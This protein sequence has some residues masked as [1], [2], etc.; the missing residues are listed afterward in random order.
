VSG[1]RSE[2]DLLAK[3]SDILFRREQL[4]LRCKISLQKQIKVSEELNREEE[5]VKNELGVLSGKDI[6]TLGISCD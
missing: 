1:K 4:I 3:L 5:K 6:P 2:E